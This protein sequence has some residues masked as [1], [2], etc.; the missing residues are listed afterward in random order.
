[1]LTHPRQEL[2]AL[3]IPRG[4]G[5]DTDTSVDEEERAPAFVIR[6]RKPRR[7][8]RSAW[9]KLS[10]DTP[11]YEL[12]DKAA[13]APRTPPSLSRQSPIQHRAS[14]DNPINN[15]TSILQQSLPPT[16]VLE[17]IPE[18]SYYFLDTPSSP[19]IGDWTFVHTA[20]HAPASTPPSEPETW[21]LLS[22]DS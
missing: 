19:S 22:D 8:R 11:F 21:I 12:R 15:D 9:E 16:S 2:F 17:S 10:I 6:Y 5:D 7:S 1:M 20:Q 18:S 14:S 13:N 3:G 4:D